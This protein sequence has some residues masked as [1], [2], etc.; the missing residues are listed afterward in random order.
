[1]AASSAYNTYDRII[2]TALDSAGLLGE[3]ELP[4]SEMYAK[5]MD[6][7]ND[8][9]NLW[10]TQGLKLWLNEMYTLTPIEGTA[11]YILTARKMRVLEGYFV[12]A[13]DQWTPL[14]PL[15]WAEYNSLSLKN[16]EGAVNSFFVNKKVDSTEVTLW[17]VPDSNAALG[18]VRLLTQVPVSNA[19]N[20]GDNPNFPQEWYMA[21]HW[22]LADEM[23]TGQPAAI[24]QRCEQKAALYRTALEAWD[25]EDTATSW[26]PDFG[27][28]NASPFRR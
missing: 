18:T 6:R 1:M 3:G 25:T 22:G 24:V 17:M 20:L 16:R 9:I 8:L 21:L 10:Q 13:N 2:R 26:A 19:G 11:T 27:G 5:C 15:S 14:D 4:T 23:C 7:V 28:G 12:D